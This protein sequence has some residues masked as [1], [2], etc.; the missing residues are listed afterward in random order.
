VVLGGP[1]TIARYT[2]RALRW[3]TFPVGVY[4]HSVTLDSAGDA[5]YNGHF[6]LDPEIVGRVAAATGE[7]T[8]WVVPRH[9]GLGAG[10]GGP[11]PYEI[12][13][14][15][16][17]GVW[18]SELAGNRVFRLDPASGTF[19]VREMPEPHSGPR[20]LDVDREGNVWIPAYGTNELVRLD[21]RTGQFSRRPLPIRDAVPYV[22]RL[23]HGTGMVWIGTSAGDVVLAFD[24]ARDQFTAYPLSPGALVRHLAVDP[25]T[26]EVWV[27]YGAFPGRLSAR[28]ARISP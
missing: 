28:I 26:H 4:P 3:S 9:P 19:T 14:A 8:R 7:V 12:R 20:R 16:D 13:A 2:P 21:G 25:R 17:G 15:A 24:P 1:A 6:T 5:W 22:V 23:D 27:A 10:P 11:I 18:G